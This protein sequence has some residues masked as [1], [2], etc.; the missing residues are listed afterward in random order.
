M[1]RGRALVALS[2]VAGVLAV[3]GVAL[4]VVVGRRT[5]AFA[6]CSETL[7]ADE[8]K[9]R[10]DRWPQLTDDLPGVGEYVEIHWQTRAVG[11]PCSRVPGPT[12]WHYQGL[13]RLRAED[14]H[15]LAKGY[16]W[17]PMSVSPSPGTYQFDTPT[18]M[19]PAL[20]PFA[21]AETRWLHSQSYASAQSFEHGRWGDL[22]FDP[23]NGMAFFVLLDH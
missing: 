18:Q 3:A 10:T 14:A 9:V 4:A 8:A 11:N 23:A 20:V 22:Y 12:D 2:T 5:S 21:P 16:D 15:A 17:Q 1:R 13:V 6:S 19:W 7:R